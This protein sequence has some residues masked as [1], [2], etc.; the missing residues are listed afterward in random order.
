M[1]ELK[2]DRASGPDF[3]EASS[4]APGTA[5]RAPTAC[6]SN[7]FCLHYLQPR[8]SSLQ[9]PE[10]NRYTTKLNPIQLIENKR[11]RA[12]QIATK[13]RFS[14]VRCGHSGGLIHGPETGARCLNPVVRGLELRPGCGVSTSR[15]PNGAG[16][17]PGAAPNHSVRGAA[18][19][20]PTGVPSGH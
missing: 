12:R 13:S 7:S 1:R 14:G 2:T 4:G 19:G 8:A 5:C 15:V 9:I 3:S 6:F 20:T 16:R 11:W 17:K 10:S 18:S